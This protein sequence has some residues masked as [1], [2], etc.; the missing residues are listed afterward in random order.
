MHTKTPNG[1]NEGI[2][3]R[4]KIN[5]AQLEASTSRG[6]HVGDEL[7]S[8]CLLEQFQYVDLG[9]DD[10]REAYNQITGIMDEGLGVE[11]RCMHVVVN[12]LRSI[13]ATEFQAFC[14]LFC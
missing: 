13:T 10:Q 11:D 3:L 8:L 6:G 9:H 7:I 2:N 4:K 14:L 5:L 12:G 1:L